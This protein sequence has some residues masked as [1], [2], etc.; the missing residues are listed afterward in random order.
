M[1]IFPIADEQLEALDRAGA[2]SWELCSSRD[3]HARQRAISL[4][5]WLNQQLP[6]AFHL[7]ISG[8]GACILLPE[9]VR[10]RFASQLPE[11]VTAGS[12]TPLQEMACLASDCVEAHFLQIVPFV[13]WLE[14]YSPGAFLLFPDPAGKYWLL[15]ASEWSSLAAALPPAPPSLLLPFFPPADE[16]WSNPRQR[17]DQAPMALAACA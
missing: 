17:R 10:A 6:G 3:F 1:R 8:S 2:D 4:F 14:C 7:S 9:T 13:H 16:Y 12:A 15:A 5:A 11:P